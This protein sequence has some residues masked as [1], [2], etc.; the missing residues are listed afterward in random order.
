MRHTKLKSD[1]DYLIVNLILTHYNTLSF[2]GLPAILSG[3]EFDTIVKEAES[4]Y[5]KELHETRDE[6]IRN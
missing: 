2:K 5:Y 4:I 6:N 3:D 1:I